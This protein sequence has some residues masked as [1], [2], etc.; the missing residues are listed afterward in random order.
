MGRV[1]THHF[2]NF[3]HARPRPGRFTNCEM[4]PAP[5]CLHDERSVSSSVLIVGDATKIDKNRRQ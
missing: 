5:L 2:H 3:D 4:A 1:G